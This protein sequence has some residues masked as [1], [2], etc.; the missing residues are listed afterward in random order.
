MPHMGRDSVSLGHDIRAQWVKI[1]TSDCRQLTRV[2][3]CLGK[4]FVVHPKDDQE[5]WEAFKLGSYM[6]WLTILQC[7][8]GCN[9]T[10]GEARWEVRPILCQGVRDNRLEGSSENAESRVIQEL[11][12]RTRGGT[13]RGWVR[14]EESSGGFQQLWILVLLQMH[15]A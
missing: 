10:A 7:H 8:F 9:K 13:R 12:N 11:L 3:H 4:E 2:H 6:I 1:R 5:P 14:K 15:K